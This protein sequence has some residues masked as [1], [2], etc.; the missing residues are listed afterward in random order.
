MSELRLAVRTLAKA[1]AFSLITIAVVALGIGATTAVFTIVNGVLLQPLD[2]HAPDQL[3]LIREGVSAAQRLGYPWVP[4]NPVHYERWRARVPAFSAYAISAEQAVDVTGD[5]REPELARMANVSASLFP[6]L[7]VDP[8][9]GRM[10]TADDDRAGRNDVA[11]LSH[12]MWQRRFGADPQAVGRV[13]MVNGTS[14]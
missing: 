2:F 7:G 8:Q 5:D 12:A 11:I 14:L 9:I 1:R 3:Y 4:A 13:I 10:F 6:M